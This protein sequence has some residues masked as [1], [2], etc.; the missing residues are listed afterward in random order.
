MCDGILKQGVSDQDAGTT[1]PG[2]QVR[3]SAMPQW[4][5]GGPAVPPL[6]CGWCC[7]WLLLKAVAVD[8]IAWCAG[9]CK[10][11]AHTPCLTLAQD[12]VWQQRSSSGAPAVCVVPAVACPA[13]PC[14]SSAHTPTHTHDTHVVPHLTLAQE[15]V[16]QQRDSSCAAARA[17]LDRLRVCGW[18]H[19]RLHPKAGTRVRGC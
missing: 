8:T 18:G 15:E 2:H 9:P 3:H 5:A 11:S 16:W 13:G 6:M 12:E 17:V 19:F 14:E 7:A 4:A 1:A 10:H